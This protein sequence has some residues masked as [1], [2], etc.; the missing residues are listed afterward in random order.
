M[1]ERTDLPQWQN[2]Q[3]LAAELGGRQVRDLFAD[4]P[5]RH[6]ALSVE[7]LDLL[8]D[9][10]RQ[11]VT[12]DVVTELCALAGACGLE[13]R[14]AALF[15]GEKVNSTES[16]PAL[17][18]ALRNLS[19]R[20]MLADGVDVMP[21]VQAE[22]GKLRDFVTG[23]HEGRITGFTGARFT[24]VVNIGIG[25]SDL[26]IVMAAEALARYRNRNVRLHCV[27]N[28]DG[29]ELADTL[30]RIDPCPHAVRDLFEDLHDTRNPDQCAGG[31][32]VDGWRTRREGSAEALRCRL[33]QPSRDGRVWCFAR[34]A[35]HDLGLG[36][37]P[38]FAMVRRRAVDCAGA[39]IRCIRAD[40]GGRS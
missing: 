30:E 25:G 20:P 23:V 33:D 36:G 15:G 1:S 31:A 12:G 26:G 18:M 11:R 13:E 10:S 39:R 6:A 34:R 14:R 9:Y 32:R 37:R 17:H 40:A 2:L 29:V 22:L 7:T 16:R 8:Y 28:V 27:S 5:G 3:R 19:G 21:A 38:L 24:D 35:V 4:E